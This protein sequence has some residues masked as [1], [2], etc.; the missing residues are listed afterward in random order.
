MLCFLFF[1]F[2]QALA[3]ENHCMVICGEW[4]NGAGN[5]WDFVV[6]K[7]Q[8]AT[9]VHVHDTIY[10]TELKESVLREFLVDDR[11]YN[12]SLSYWSPSTHEL[13]TGITTPLFYSLAMELLSIFSS[14]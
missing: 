11:V 14:I 3:M 13:A 6:D 7:Q 5:K 10:L 4:V 8:M 12:A 1:A 9:L 2:T